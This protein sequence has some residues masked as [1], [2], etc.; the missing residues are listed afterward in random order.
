M[1]QPS[2]STLQDEAW[3]YAIGVGFT[4]LLALAFRIAMLINRGRMLRFFGISSSCPKLDVYLSRLMVVKTTG[5]EEIKVGYQGPAVQKLELDGAILA[6]DLLKSRRVAVLPQPVR[7]M[8]GRLFISI[9]PVDP[10]IKVS[11]EKNDLDEMNKGQNIISLGSQVYNSVFQK[12]NGQSK[13]FEFGKDADGERAIR[14]K[15]EAFIGDHLT[16]RNNREIG[17]IERVNADNRSV[18]YCAGLGASA[19]FGCVRYL[20]ENWEKLYERN[21]LS[22]FALFLVFQEQG[23]NEEKVGK[24][25]KPIY[26]HEEEKPPARWKR[27]F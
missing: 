8:L 3:K 27:W 20:I 22:E 9:A 12:H 14:V 23:S 7:K 6:R 11:P 24:P 1:M 21:G 5:W 2:L 17:I 19:T 15:Q 4:I 10:S 25:D 26:V 18:F 13:Y 16:R